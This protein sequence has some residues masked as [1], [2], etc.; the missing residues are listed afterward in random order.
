MEIPVSVSY[1][2]L[3]SRVA[4]YGL[5]NLPTQLHW[6]WHFILK[7]EPLVPLDRCQIMSN[8]FSKHSSRKPILITI[9]GNS[10]G[11]TQMWPNSSKVSISSMDKT[12]KLFLSQNKLFWLRF[13]SFKDDVLRLLVWLWRPSYKHNRIYRSLI[14][15]VS[16]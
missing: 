12:I 6:M 5:G 15:V 13:K 16:Y 14:L 10:C 2:K 9:I 3:F 1:V 11:E 4:C 8:K 7:S